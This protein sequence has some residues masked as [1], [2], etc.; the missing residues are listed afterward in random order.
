LGSDERVPISARS[1]VDVLLQSTAAEPGIQVATVG[2]QSNVAAAVADDGGFAARVSR[3]AVMGGVFAAQAGFAPADDHNLNADPSGAITALNAGVP[4]LFVPGNVTVQT[5]LLERHLERLR[6]GDALCQALAMLTDRWAPILRQQ[7]TG[8]RPGQVAV[9]HD[10]LTVACMVERR[11]VRTAD[12]PV[13]VA[14]HGGLV[15]T[16]IDPVSGTDAEVV[17]S[18]D[19]EGFADYLLDVVLT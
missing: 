13:T 7:S 16:F 14:L 12:L 18:V 3:L 2:M 8:V 9:L 6:R 10:P 5:F 1:A 19:A 4:T 15:R 17:T 11:F